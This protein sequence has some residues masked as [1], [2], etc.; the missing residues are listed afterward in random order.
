M[1]THNL[2]IT[3]TP[4][5]EVIER[6]LRVTRHRGFKVTKM[7]MHTQDDNQLSI[8]IWVE[9]ERAIEL[10]SLQ[11]EKLIDVIQCKIMSQVSSELTKTVN[12]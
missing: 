10:L 12:G 4:Q 7:N 11:L 3:V 2:E 1:K 5:P 6:V 9:A 8:Q